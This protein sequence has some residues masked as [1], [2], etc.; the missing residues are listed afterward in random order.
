MRTLNSSSRELTTSFSDE[1]YL[2]QFITSCTNLLH[3]LHT[4]SP[5]VVEHIPR[6]GVVDLVL[7]IV[8]KRF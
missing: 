5:Y 7:N 3:P 8:C 6:H 1:E 4:S 2:F